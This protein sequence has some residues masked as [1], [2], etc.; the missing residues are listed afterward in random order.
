MPR[1]HAETQKLHKTSSLSNASIPGRT[2][3]EPQPPCANPR[4][5][6]LANQRIKQ[7][8]TGAGD[9]NRT[10]IGSLEGYCPTFRPRPLDSFIIGKSNFRV[11]SA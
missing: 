7:A 6:E 9:G 1:M 4:G 11:K 2:G 5:T 3:G 8:G 10:R